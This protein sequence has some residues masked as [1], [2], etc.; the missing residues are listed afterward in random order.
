V[1]VVTGGTKQTSSH[2]ETVKGV[3]ARRENFPLKSNVSFS[4]FLDLLC[5]WNNAPNNSPLGQ[6][7]SV[8]AILLVFILAITLEVPAISLYLASPAE[9]LG[10]SILNHNVKHNE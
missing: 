2:S 1:N 5:K 8:E 9:S 6:Y 10:F 7:V 3:M 4:F